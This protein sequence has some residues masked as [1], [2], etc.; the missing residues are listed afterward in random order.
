MQIIFIR[1]YRLQ[2]RA[3]CKKKKSDHQ[4]AK[5][6]KVLLINKLQPSPIFLHSAYPLGLGSLGRY[7][8]GLGLG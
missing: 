1:N 5:R 8:V 6:G 3:S 4:E 7:P 2:L